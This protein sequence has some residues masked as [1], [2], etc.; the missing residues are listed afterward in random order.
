[1]SRAVADVEALDP[2]ADTLFA[3]AQTMLATR[4]ADALRAARQAQALA[5][6]RSDELGVVRSLLLE[7]MARDA[8]GHAERD[9]VLAEALRLAEGLAEPVTLVRA[10]NAQLVVDIYHGRYADALARGRSMLGLAHVLG[11]DDLLGRLLNNLGT[12]LSLIGEFERAISMFSDFHRLLAGDSAEARQQRLRALNNL[13]MAWLGLARTLPAERGEGEPRQALDR[14]RALSEAACQGTLREPHIALRV[15]ALDTLVGVLLE[16]GEVDQAMAWVHRVEQASLDDLAR[17]SVI[18]GTFALARSRVELADPACPLPP[19]LACLREIEALPGPRF[20]GGEMQAVLNRCLADALERS[21]EHRD[22][23]LYHRRW[24]QFEA[25]TQSLLAREHAMAVHHTLDSLSGETEEFITHDLRNPL[26]AALVQMDAVPPQALSSAERARLLAARTGV[27]RAFNTAEH[28]LAIVRM[29]NLRRTDL[30]PID[31]AELVD[32]VGE[33]LAPPAGAQVRLERTLDWGLQVR[34][35][36]I[37]LLTALTQLLRN[38]LDHAPAGSAVEWHLTAT[39][40][41]AVLTVT[42]S[43]VGLPA[44]M[45]Q[46][47]LA[48]VGP[49]EAHRGSGLGLT[50]IA[51]VAQV[52]DAQI[53]VDDALGG[54]RIAISFPLVDAAPE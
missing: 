17:G 8:L 31:L 5:R 52:H 30:K 54:T 33:R 15:S 23:L 53:S 40:G 18:W 35:D 44:A 45:R 6:E 28:Y 50:M 41:A 39:P 21:G 37:S 32:D 42:D 20:R 3:R 46:R 16:R 2:S 14:A 27:Q 29:R 51:K 7:G 10:V 26:G 43:G 24:L 49:T 47:L 48:P 1:M 13:A 34:G 22:A 25:R 9:A 12:A 38:A 36:R 11:R 19:V 4:P